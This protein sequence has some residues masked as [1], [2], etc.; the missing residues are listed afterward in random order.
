MGLHRS[1]EGHIERKITMQ[2]SLKSFTIWSW[3]AIKWAGLMD[4]F[5]SYLEM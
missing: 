3:E 5:S 4:E 2:V 1:I